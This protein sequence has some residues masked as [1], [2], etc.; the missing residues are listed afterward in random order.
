MA[1]ALE[2]L[3]LRPREITRRVNQILEAVGLDH[4]ANTFPQMLSGGEQQRVTIAR[5]LVNEPAILLAD[6][7]T[8]NLDP[9]HFEKANGRRDRSFVSRLPFRF[10][11][12]L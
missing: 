12:I 6:E 3:G 8:G 11:A 1:I 9:D 10:L 4:Y 5:A 7:P 2:I